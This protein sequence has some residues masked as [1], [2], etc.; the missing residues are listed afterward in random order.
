MEVG[1]PVARVRAGQGPSSVALLDLDRDGRLDLLVANGTNGDMSF[2]LGNGAGGFAP[3]AGSP[4]RAGIMPS[5]IAIADFD[6][7]GQADLAIANHETSHVTV[8][9]AGSGFDSAPGSPFDTGSRPHVHSVAAGDLDGD[10]AVDLVTESVDTDSVAVLFGDGRGGF[11]TTRHFGA[12]PRPYFL[13]RVGDLDGDGR[14]EVVAPN[15]GG[16]SL[17]VLTATGRGGLFPAPGSPIPVG[18]GP[19]S[20]A[21]GD[22]NGDG[23][24]DLVVLHFE[25]NRVSDRVSV[26]LAQGGHTF[27]P[28][29]GSPFP[30]GRDPTNLALGD[31]DGDGVLDLAA[32]NFSS[33]DVTLLLSDRQARPGALVRRVPVGRN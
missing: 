29:S 16:S 6:R 21:I 18:R 27:R 25:E 4:R 23:R 32:S 5:D 1:G 8:L 22:L 7:N 11:E 28:A 33:D 10:G 3:A 30:A 14:P 2:L 24:S 13:L 19:H 31:V 26:F 12:G 20:V 17:T 9:L 15:S